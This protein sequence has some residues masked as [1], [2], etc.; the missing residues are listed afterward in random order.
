MKK[1]KTRKTPKSS[2][3]NPNLNT[4]E[5]DLNSYFVDTYLCVY[6]KDGNLKTREELKTEKAKF[7]KKIS[8]L[9]DV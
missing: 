2:E 7:D 4:S 6:K 1:T 8:Y 3:N 9:K 5:L